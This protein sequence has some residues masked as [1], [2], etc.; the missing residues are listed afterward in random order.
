M[1]G[2]QTQNDNF[3]TLNGESGKMTFKIKWVCNFRGRRG[4][5]VL[6]CSSNFVIVIKYLHPISVFIA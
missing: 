1:Q 2:K 6:K 4:V 5:I 3:S